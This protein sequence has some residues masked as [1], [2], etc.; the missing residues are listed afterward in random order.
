MCCNKLFKWYRIC[1]NSLCYKKHKMV[2]TYDIHYDKEADFIEVFFG[3][4]TECYADEPQK[5][6]F[7]RKDENTNE[8]KSIGIVS[9][10]K[11]T[12]ILQELLRKFKIDFPIDFKI[13]SN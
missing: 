6:I 8:I 11:R 4:Q 9:F 3:D 10:S 12:Q 5:G 13:N 7:V 1:I 2:K